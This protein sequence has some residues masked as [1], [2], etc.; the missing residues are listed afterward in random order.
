MCAITACI[1]ITTVRELGRTEVA[2][3]AS[4]EK[5]VHKCSHLEHAMVIDRQLMGVALV[6][7]C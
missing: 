6:N 4:I 3:G 7:R 1:V 5:L 2:W